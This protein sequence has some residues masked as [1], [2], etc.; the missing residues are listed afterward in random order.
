[1]YEMKKNEFSLFDEVFINIF[2]AYLSLNFA[3]S[4]FIDQKLL[5]TRS[6]DPPHRFKKNSDN[7]G[8]AT[9]RQTW[10]HSKV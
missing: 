5:H 2:F 9:N 8:L 1:M 4:K 7:V 10:S 3:S 6:F